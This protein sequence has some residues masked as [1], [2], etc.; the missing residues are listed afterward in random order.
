MRFD[1]PSRLA[2]EQG[3]PADNAARR[4]RRAT[5]ACLALLYSL[6]T[7]AVPAHAFSTEAAADASMTSETT[8]QPA[9]NDLVDVHAFRPIKTAWSSR[10]RLFPAQNPQ[11][12]F[13]GTWAGEIT[14]TF[15]TALAQADLPGD[16]SQQIAR[17]LRGKVDMSAKGWQGD[18]VRVAYE[19]V[20][21]ACCGQDIRLT[22]V[23]VRFQG[24]SHAG[25]W[26][27]TT[28][29]PQ[30]DYYR[31]DGTLMSGLRYTLP[32]AAKRVSS[33]FGERV[34][35]VT[36]ARHVHSG[37]DLAASKGTAVHVSADGVVVRI[38]NEPRGFGKYVAVQHPD[39]HTSYYAHL[40]KIERGL[41]V[42]T[43]IESGRRIGA[44]GST[45]TATGPHL[46]FEVR[47]GDQLVDPTA[48]LAQAGKRALKGDQMAA[49]QRVARAAKVRLAA[50]AVAA[51]TESLAAM[52]VAQARVC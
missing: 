12:P 41:R 10:T 4:A 16:L 13:S 46:H 17:L 8:L 9:A 51:G 37:V 26:F 49:F 43:R 18:Y 50:A 28:D 23:E 14:T 11:N 15:R 24:K 40:S 48:L 20:D 45:G 31:F 27:A 33:A 21:G 5:C 2:R 47:L 25:V 36:G 3:Q 38:G 32:V 29:R 30:G 22:A 35:P 44:V 34:H 42:G 6:M 19:P 52:R 7:A 39:G 1:L